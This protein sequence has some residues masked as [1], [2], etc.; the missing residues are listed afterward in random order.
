MSDEG[1]SASCV[2]R[3][4]SRRGFT[5]IELLT[6]IA[7]IAILAGLLT[8]GFSKTAA[9]G[10]S[11]S[12]LG[13]LK[14]LQLGSLVYSYDYDDNLP[15]NKWRVEDWQNDCPEGGQAAADSWVL[16]DATKDKDTWNIQNGT[17]FPYINDSRV[18]HCPTDKS[19]VIWNRKI[20]RKRSYSL[21]FYMN[22]E[23]RY[24]QVKSKSCQISRPAEVFTFLD[25]HEKSITSG[26]FFLHWPHCG[27]E[28]WVVSQFGPKFEGGHWMQMPADRHNQGCNLSYADGSARP[29]KWLFPKNVDDNDAAVKS[30]ADFTDYRWLQQGIPDP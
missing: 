10:K 17:L 2:C 9:K 18:Y 13:N 28:Q 14:Q 21:S 24:S 4:F 30:E 12:C 16:G 29:R 23:A 27:A 7:I 3:S 22:G 26:V 5:L 1:F 6:V 11:L 25:E 20:Q 8:P 19:G 15:P